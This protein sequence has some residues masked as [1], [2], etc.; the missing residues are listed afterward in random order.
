MCA[1]HHVAAFLNSASKSACVSPWQLGLPLHRDTPAYIS[2]RTAHT[3]SMGADR[4]KED[5]R[6]WLL[7]PN[8]IL[9]EQHAKKQ[10]HSS[11]S[12][13]SRPAAKTRR[14]Q[15]EPANGLTDTMYKPGEF[16]VWTPSFG[17]LAYL[18]LLLRLCAAELVSVVCVPAGAAAA[19]ATEHADCSRAPL[20][21]VRLP[22]PSRSLQPDRQTQRGRVQALREVLHTACWPAAA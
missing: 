20:H 18:L 11:T 6:A 21:T 12:T 5:P 2:C 10:Q 15:T 8:P 16:Q 17:L 4:S 1:R 13:T 9:H 7:K 22:G 14:P 19:A 3:H